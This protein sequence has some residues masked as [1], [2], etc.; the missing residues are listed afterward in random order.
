MTELFCIEGNRMTLVDR[1]AVQHGLDRSAFVVHTRLVVAT[2]ELEPM[3]VLAHIEVEP[4]FIVK[5]LTRAAAARRMK[6][7]EMGAAIALAKSAS[8]RSNDLLV[9]VVFDRAIPA[10]N[11]D[12][13]CILIAAAN[14]FTVGRRILWSK[15]F[16]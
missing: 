7:D 4:V 6:S 15:N 8:D 11:P 5:R 3:T 9:H 1:L 10:Q 13:G 14:P 2:G 12:H 16:R